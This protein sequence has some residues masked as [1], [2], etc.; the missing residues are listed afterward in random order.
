MSRYDLL[1]CDADMTLL[2]FERAEEAAFYEACRAKGLSV[3]ETERRR[4]G[5]LNAACWKLFEQG[6]LTQPQLRVKRFADF[7]GELGS[8]TDPAQLSRTY[9]TA[10]SHQGFAL[11]GAREALTRW[12][13]RIRVMIVTN[14]IAAVQH[15]RFAASPFPELAEDLVISE[16]VGSAKPAPEIL[17]E[18]MRRAGAA[19]RSR[20]LMLGDSL[21]SDIAAAYRAG[22]DAC[23]FNPK[24]KKNET[25]LPIRWEVASLDEVDALL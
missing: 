2:D 21:S 11:P 1:L 8:G 12:K 9:E 14:G 3:G 18:A 22:V 17:W 24:H 6:K 20:V 16:E 4:Y 5:E 7:L 10:L 13:R 19:D 15:G 25:G 23:W